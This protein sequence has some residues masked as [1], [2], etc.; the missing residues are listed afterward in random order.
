MSFAKCLNSVHIG[1]V[2][3]IDRELGD[4]AHLGTHIRT[5]IYIK[6][7]SQYLVDYSPAIDRV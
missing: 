5:L 6:R 7:F 3:Q 2:D 4:F 1:G